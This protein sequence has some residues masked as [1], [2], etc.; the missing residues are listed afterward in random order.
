MALVRRVA[1]IAVAALL[2]A[3]LAL[4]ALIAVRVDWVP[5]EVRGPV[6][7][8]VVYAFVGA[9]S[10]IERH[11]DDVQFDPDGDS[12]RADVIILVR[13]GADGTTNAVSLPR[14]AIAVGRGQPMRYALTLLDGPQSL[15]DAV[16]AGTG[17]SIDRFV[18]VDGGSFVAAI[19]ALGGL[20][21]EIPVEMRD[22]AADLLITETGAQTIDGAT[23]LALVRSR[24]AEHL[25]DGAWVARSDEAGTADRMSWSA[26]VLDGVR[27]KLASAPPWSFA[28]AA[29][30]A[31]AD[32]VVGGGLHPG[33][34][35]Q[36]ASKPLVIE[37]LPTDILAEGSLGRALGDEG[38]KVIVDAGFAT[39]CTIASP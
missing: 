15:V 17:I 7:G 22:P 6:G 19:D 26:T 29:W 38:R 3:A 20:D 10:G 36:L 16:C 21:V 25:K 18:S 32:L 13:L 2:V 12:A 1:L 34:L 39:D 35:R 31:S 27:A 28:S 14:D 37:T 11:P 9:D 30:A 24:H 5:L 4:T 8:D 33:E 23:A